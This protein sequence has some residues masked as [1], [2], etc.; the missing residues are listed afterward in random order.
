MQFLKFFSP[1]L[2]FKVGDVIQIPFVDRKN[3]EEKV[4]GFSRDCVSL[5]KSDWDSFE[6]SWDFKKHPLV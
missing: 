6:T 3:D 5:S 1:T 4:T 2:D